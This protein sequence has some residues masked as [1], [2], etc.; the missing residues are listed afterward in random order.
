MFANLRI[1]RKLSAAFLVL[2]V[3]VAVMSGL[4]LKS[5]SA[6]E[7]ANRWNSHTYEVLDSAADIISAMVDQET[8]VRG[9]LVS[10]DE[11]F[12]APYISGQALV[13]KALDTTQ[14]LTSDNAEQQRRIR[15][16]KAL[17]NEWRVQVAEPEIKLMRDPS[18]REQARA[19]EASG[20]GKKSM[21]GIRALHQ[22]LDKAERDLLV[23]RSATRDGAMNVAFWSLIIGGVAVISLAI[24]MGV[25]LTRGIAGPVS[26]MSSVMDR[27]AAG[28][29]TVDVPAM[30][31]K[32]EVGQMAKAVL[33]F[34]EA[35]IEKVR[36]E[37]EGA[38][39]RRQAEAD[40]AR[41]DAERASLAEQQAAVVA[42]LAAGLAQL[43]EGNLTGRLQ[44]FPQDY[45]QLERDFNLAIAKLEDT[46]SVIAGNSQGIH[47]GTGEIS[48]AADNLSKRTEQQ[49][50]SLEETAAALDEI[51]A[52]V[53]KTAEGAR[54]ASD[55]VSAAKVDAENSGKI[56][57]DAVVAM[58]AIEK[59]A[60]EISQIIGV[61]DEIAFQTNLLAL[62][63][64]VEAA[65][66][67]EAG[68]GFAVVASEVRALAQRSAEAAKEIKAL[69]SASTSQVS[70]GV[71]L[72]GETGKALT[73]IV[74]QVTEISGIV[75]EI[76][77]STQEQATGLH[78]VN[79]AVNQM[80]QVT[81][82]NAAMVEE[83]TAASR[84]LAE[85]AEKLSSLVGQ[86]RTGQEA[87]PAAARR[88]DMAAKRPRAANA[89]RRAAP[90]VSRGNTALALVADQSEETWEEF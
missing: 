5:L 50:A 81:Q 65:R 31:R 71:N 41:N 77:A 13:G 83:S 61:I 67:G 40:R 43:A 57:Q 34:K 86:F 2:V 3:A 23:V 59:S 38:E 78:Q 47:S 64:G 53:R 72:V 80:D 39:Q 85:E 48:Q 35:A 20:A 37:A 12:L 36:L 18:T 44:A 4:V 66:A 17:V 73:R 87:A 15:D 14:R 49:A 19:L 75:M 62:N 70:S 88:P 24:L 56:V 30:G 79:T 54:H 52:T 82:Q 32:D 8:G 55:V 25:V 16:L 21:D 68:K 84:A 60:Q 1:S 58:G 42:D 90:P 26:A 22:A 11:K 46:I 33:G 27:L 63:A 45:K 10:G 89:P 28:D 51:T 74:G 6:V 69:I 29:N 9:Y 7:D 76:S